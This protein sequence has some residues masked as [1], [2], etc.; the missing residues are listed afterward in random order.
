LLEAAVSVGRGTDTPFEV[1]GAPY[2]DDVRFAAALNE[3]GLAGVRF[4]PIRFTP[5]ASTFK[6]EPCGGV[7]LVVADRAALASLD[8][9][10]L[11]ASTLQRM[12]PG[13]FALD[14]MAPLLQSEATLAGIRSGRSVPEIRSLWAAELKAFAARREK[15]LLYR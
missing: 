3:A 11:L 2:V 15:F 14:K 7:S 6:D 10:M 12:Y 9:G 8:V 13:Q 4:V 5:R 1:V